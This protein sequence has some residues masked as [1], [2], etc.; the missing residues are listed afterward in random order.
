MPKLEALWNGVEAD[1]IVAK[2]LE[3]CWR[4]LKWS[5]GM[6]GADKRIVQGRVSG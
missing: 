3:A 6:N 4:E 5:G 2:G 1:P